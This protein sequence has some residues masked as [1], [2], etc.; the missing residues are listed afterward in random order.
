MPVRLRESQSQRKSRSKR[1]FQMDVQLD[2]RRFRV[3]A[4]TRLKSVAEGR[5]RALL[6]IIK[7]HPNISPAE[8]RKLFRK[9]VA[10][11]TI[12]NIELT[13]V[14]IRYGRTST[15]TDT[16]EVTLRDA[17]YRALN[18]PSLRWSSNRSQPG[19][20][21]NCETL[22]SFYGAS[23]SVSKI[24]REAVIRLI[25]HLK[26]GQSRSGSPKRGLTPATINR[27]L[28]TLRGVLKACVTWGVLDALPKNL[29]TKLKGERTRFFVFTVDQ[30]RRLIAATEAWDQ[31]PSPQPGAGR[32]PV[33]DGHAIANL[34]L[35]LV[36]TGLR[37]GEAL[38]AG[39]QDVDFINGL[40]S[41]GLRSD[42]AVKS[43]R[44]RRRIPLTSCAQRILREL[45]GTQL[46]GPFRQITKRRAQT[47][48]SRAKAACGITDRDCVIHAF[49]HTCATRLLEGTGDIALVSRWLGHS[50]VAITDKH[51]AHVL[52]GHLRAG[53][54]VLDRIRE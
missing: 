12:D 10:G 3:S 20:R 50:S 15:S 54:A 7:L 16:A 42:Y 6:R 36:E 9:V 24:D 23:M 40:L 18:D 44:S 52:T 45:Q 33:R 4:G 19:E 5:E 34:F 1:S 11:S 8:V 48:F 32:P 41:V 25:T 51:Y 35:F 30:E 49:R 29:P 28:S 47:A 31:M 26:S 22:I 21:T 43:D 38:N 53:A 17:C 13:S 14:D 2:H 27:K 37:I 46:D 39:W